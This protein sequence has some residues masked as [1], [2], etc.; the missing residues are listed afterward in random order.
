MLLGLAASLSQAAAPQ[1]SVP[2][3]A[4][5]EK[6]EARMEEGYENNYMKEHCGYFT[7]TAEETLVYLRSAQPLPTEQVHDRLDWVQCIVQGTLVS[8]KGKH[9]KEVRFEISASLAA[10]IYEPGKPVAY[11]ICEGTCE[12]RMN[13]IIEKHVHGK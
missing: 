9:R 10:H 11:L 12:E 6:L 1:W 7:L 4:R 13:K 2:R 3:D 8:G 5:I